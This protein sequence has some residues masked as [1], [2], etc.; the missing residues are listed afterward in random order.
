MIRI[1]TKLFKGKLSN[2]EVE[3]IEEAKNQPS[4]SQEVT[5]DVNDMGGDLEKYA[6]EIAAFNQDEKS[7]WKKIAR[8]GEDFLIEQKSMEGHED[9]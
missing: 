7:V 4:T 5:L 6:R 3:I 8:E 1:I 9:I 2:G